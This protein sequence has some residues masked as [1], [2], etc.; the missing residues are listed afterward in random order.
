MI[1]DLLISLGIAV[2]LCSSALGAQ[3]PLERIRENTVLI[4]NVQ[5]GG[6]GEGTG[7]LIDPI[8][9]LTCFHM[10]ETPKDDFMVFTYPLGKVIRAHAE[11]G[12]KNDDLLVLV[13]DSSVP[14]KSPVVFQTDY[15]IGE[16]IIVVGNALGSMQWFVSKGVISGQAQG[17]ILTDALINPGNSGGP[18]VNDK[19]EIVALTDWGI[20]P[21]PHIHGFSGGIAAKTIGELMEMR[22]AQD[23]ITQILKALG[24]K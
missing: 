1:K 20:G 13:L 6:I 24:A 16:S 22:D 23:Q 2:L 8:H 10:M 12:S 3:S 7:V 18:W 21:E 17:Y 14:I 19:G 5:I 9:V 15:T 11:G 4:S